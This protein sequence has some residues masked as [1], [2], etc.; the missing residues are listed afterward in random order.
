MNISSI[1]G[2]G[3]EAE[4]GVKKEDCT[5]WMLTELC[6]CLLS[7]IYS[8]RTLYSCINAFEDAGAWFIARLMDYFTSFPSRAANI[9]TLVSAQPGRS[10]WIGIYPSSSRTYSLQQRPLW[11]LFLMFFVNE[12][13]IL[14]LLQFVPCTFTVILV[15]HSFHK[16]ALS[17]CI[18]Y[19]AFVCYNHVRVCNL[20][21]ETCWYA[22]CPLS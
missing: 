20:K 15:I 12:Y 8:Q 17:Y 5:L 16:C 2:E 19:D 1:S 6:R 22:I 9:S 21:C 4:V 13:L 18:V 10:C 11:R 3:T 7:D 14:H